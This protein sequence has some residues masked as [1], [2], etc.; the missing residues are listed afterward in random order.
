VS[1]TPLFSVVIPTYDRLELLRHAVDSVLRQTIGDFEC[2]VVD[3]AS[4]TPVSPIPDR[5]VRVVRHPSNRGEAGSRNTGLREAVGRYVAYL[6]DDDEFTSDRLKLALGGLREAPIAICWRRGTDGTSGGNR[7]LEGYVYDHILDD[8]TPNLGQVAFV[9]TIAPEF[10]ASFKAVGDADWLL[11]VVREHPVRTVPRLGLVYRIHDGA[12]HG[13][14]TEARLQGSHLLLRKHADYFDRHP[15]AA[16]FRWKRIGLL[17]AALGNQRR[18]RRAFLRSL[19][20]R[21][22]TKTAWHFIRSLIPSGSRSPI[23]AT[24]G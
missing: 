8:L 6:D 12:R 19:R 23:G 20:L 21:P 18:A 16:A 13:N 17:C 5:R 9:R 14:G 11:R 2:I 4:P 10:D 3:D 1:G 22:E 15:R 7:R 24:S